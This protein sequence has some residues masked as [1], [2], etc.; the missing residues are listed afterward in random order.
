MIW[1]YSAGARVALGSR[2]EQMTETHGACE[3]VPRLSESQHA[4]SAWL[5]ACRS[6]WAVSADVQVLP[7]RDIGATWSY[8]L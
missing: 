4:P 3:K 1:A 2:E 5:P 8:V 6:T 7:L